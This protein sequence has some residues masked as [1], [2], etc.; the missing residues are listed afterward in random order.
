MSKFDSY[1]NEL[2]DLVNQSESFEQVDSLDEEIMLAKQAAENF[3]NKTTNINLNLLES[4]LLKIK[5]KSV[6]LNIP[7][8]TILLSIIHQYAT[9]KI[10]LGL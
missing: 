2:L 4:D 6:E 3:L 10:K 8:Q 7:Y 1:E 9:D 5:R